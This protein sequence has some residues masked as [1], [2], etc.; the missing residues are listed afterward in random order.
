MIGFQSL[1]R[2]P[3]LPEGWGDIG[4]Y[5]SPDYQRT[6]AGA[7]LFDATLAAAR[8]AGVVTINAA[9]RADNAPGLGYCT[10]RGFVDYGAD[11]DFALKDGRVVG[12]VLKRFDL[13]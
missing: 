5:V 10:R 7:A 9:I 12:R 11:P 3:A 6:G 4:S 1:G 8:Q 13:V 2:H